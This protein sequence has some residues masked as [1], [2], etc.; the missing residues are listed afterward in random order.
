MTF[1]FM[2]LSARSCPISP[3]RPGPA[4]N[5]SPGLSRRRSIRTS[6]GPQGTC[7]L[8][9]LLES[10][11]ARVEASLEGLASRIARIA[12]RNVGT[13]TS[14]LQMI[15]DPAVARAVTINRL[16]TDGRRVLTCSGPGNRFPAG[17]SFR[18]VLE[19]VS[20]TRLSIRQK[21]STFSRACA[22]SRPRAS[23]SR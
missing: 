11:Q 14:E 7:A 23:G 19:L 12:R 17:T 3:R 9:S 2:A 10:R 6:F 5:R 16:R 13:R 22:R 20:S 4:R 1:R 8:W 15:L 21:F 18:S